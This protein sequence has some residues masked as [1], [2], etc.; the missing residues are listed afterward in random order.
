MQGPICEKLMAEILID[1]KASTID[2]SMLDYKRF[3][4]KRL[5]RNTTWSTR[6]RIASFYFLP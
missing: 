2:I 6:F 3:A 5:S 4:E 1:G